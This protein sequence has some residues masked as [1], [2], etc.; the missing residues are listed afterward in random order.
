MLKID[1]TQMQTGRRLNIVKDKDFDGPLPEYP[2]FAW[3][4]GLVNAVAH[5]DYSIRGEYTRVVIF[6]DR[7]EITSPGILPNRV[8]LENM[9]TTR[10][11][12]NPKI[13]HVLASFKWVRELNEGV[14]RVYQEMEELGLPDPEFSEPS[15]FSVRLVLR[16][17]IGKRVPYMSDSIGSKAAEE[18]RT[19]RTLSDA[20]VTALNLAESEG[21]VKTAR[22]MQSVGVSRVTASSL[23]K[24]LVEKGRLV[25][26]GTGQHD[27]NQYYSQS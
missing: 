15:D 7:L 21:R 22:L 10:Y 4:E 5:R 2:E 3:F 12:R 26:H 17:D 11:A 24:R 27:P 23:L 16:N 6:D 13:C 8:T 20:E 1:G 14:H 9:R 25:W 19:E 18:R